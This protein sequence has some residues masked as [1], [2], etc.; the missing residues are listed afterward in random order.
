MV[1]ILLCMCKGSD[2]EFIVL[3]GCS[4]DT[5]KFFVVVVSS[6]K[7]TIEFHFYF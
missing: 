7:K 6:S 5:E 3:C 1:Y 4:N 2:Y